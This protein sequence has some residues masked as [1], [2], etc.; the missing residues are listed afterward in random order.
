MRFMAYDSPAPGAGLL[1]LVSALFLP[2]WTLVANAHLSHWEGGHLPNAYE[3]IVV[4][5][6]LKGW[7]LL[8][9]CLIA[10]TMSYWAASRPEWMSARALCIRHGMIFLAGTVVVLPGMIWM[11]RLGHLSLS[12]TFSSWALTCIPLSVTAI[13]SSAG[14]ARFN[15]QAGALI[16]GFVFIGLT[17][18]GGLW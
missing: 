8:F 9:G 18:R 14:G 16:G 2:A 3:M 17:M 15:G 10:G 12:D 5:Y 4:P 6:G 11:T 7:G 13:V 1:I